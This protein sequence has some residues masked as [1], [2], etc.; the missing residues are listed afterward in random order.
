MIQEDPAVHLLGV[1]PYTFNHYL[2]VIMY[3]PS[4]G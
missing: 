3:I 4:H 2:G 1:T